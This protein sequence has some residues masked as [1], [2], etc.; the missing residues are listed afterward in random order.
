MD[1]L[2]EPDMLTSWYF[3]VQDSTKR[4]TYVS[5][6]SSALTTRARYCSSL[7]IIKYEG[8]SHMPGVFIANVR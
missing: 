5:E 7:L 6:N 4:S 8:I 1:S 2:C 3:L